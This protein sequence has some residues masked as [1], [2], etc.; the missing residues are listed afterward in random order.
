MKMNCYLNKFQQKNSF[1]FNK[2]LLILRNKGF[3]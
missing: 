1:N 2:I 3:Q